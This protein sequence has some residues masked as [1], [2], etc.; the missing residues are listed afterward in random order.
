MDAPFLFQNRISSKTR[1]KCLCRFSL[2]VEKSVD[3]LWISTKKPVEKSVDNLG[4]LA[5]VDNLA[6]YPQVIHRQRRVIHNFVHR[7]NP[8][9]AQL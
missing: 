9:W 6:G 1:S 5:P 7:A 8:R 2:T 4:P 3:N